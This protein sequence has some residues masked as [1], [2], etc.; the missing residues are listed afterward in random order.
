MSCVGVTIGSA[1]LGSGLMPVS[2]AERDVHVSAIAHRYYRPLLVFFRKR[3]PPSADADD[4]VQELFARLSSVEKLSE[5]ER[6]EGYIFQTA[7]NLLR[8]GARKRAVRG[9]DEQQNYD[10][11]QFSS[12]EITPERVLLGKEQVAELLD[13]LEML[14][15]RT[16]TVFILKRFENFRYGEIA[17]RLGISVSS[18]E[19]HMAKAIKKLYSILDDAPHD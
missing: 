15:E 16:R 12:D 8:D 9:E 3:L 2:K 6:I 18:V 7:A 10:A 14:P 19:K 5:I 4:Y 17:R 11:E 1:S 13:A